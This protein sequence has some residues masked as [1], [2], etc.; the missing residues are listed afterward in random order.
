[1]SLST[2]LPP[3]D[4]SSDVLHSF[5]MV[6]PPVPSVVSAL[7]IQ[8]PLLLVAIRDNYRLYQYSD[9]FLSSGN[10]LYRSSLRVEVCSRTYLVGEYRQP[11]ASR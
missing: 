10:R 1:M 8:Y 3:L 11:L 9:W 5:Q 2:W 7:K 4:I 6:L